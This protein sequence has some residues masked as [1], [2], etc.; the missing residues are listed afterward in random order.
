MLTKRTANPGLIWNYLNGVVN[1]YK[2]AGISVAQVRKTVI[3][4]LCRGKKTQFLQTEIK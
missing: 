1:I 2:P 4:N 3:T